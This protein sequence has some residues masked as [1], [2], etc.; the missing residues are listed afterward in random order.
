MASVRRGATL[1]HFRH[2][3]SLKAAPCRG[4]Q[5]PGIP[6][7]RRITMALA[8]LACTVVLADEAPRS[9]V[10]AS[11]ILQKSRGSAEYQSYAAEFSQFNNHFHLDTKDG[12]YA[13]SPGPVNLML[14]ISHGDNEEFAVVERVLSDVDNA[15]AQCF[16]RAYR[17]LR[18]KIPP[19]LP[20]V[21]QLGMG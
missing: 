18:T 20:F 3:F 15:K 7:I 12:C 14:V 21:L 11:A 17:G 2:A 10:D 13:L 4:L 5:R 1:A 8:L 16:Q 9:Y 6:M 19:F